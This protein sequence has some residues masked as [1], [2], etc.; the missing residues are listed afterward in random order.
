MKFFL[1]VC[2]FLNAALAE[3]PKTAH[4]E[5]LNERARPESETDRVPIDSAEVIELEEALDEL[6]QFA[7]TRPT[8]EQEV[9]GS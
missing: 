8:G 6:N 9:A 3:T 1:A 5:T 2:T 4:T 7:P